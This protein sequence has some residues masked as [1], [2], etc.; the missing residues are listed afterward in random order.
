MLIKAS[1]KVVINHF[2]GVQLS[3]EALVPGYQ[4][5][6]GSRESFDHLHSKGRLKILGRF[7]LEA[8]CELR[9]ALVVVERYRSSCC[10]GPSIGFACSSTKVVV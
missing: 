8:E 6:E 7:K 5:S 1:Q 10:G 4:G 3:A 2:A 9:L